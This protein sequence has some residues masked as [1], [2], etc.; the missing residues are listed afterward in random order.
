MGAEPWE[1]AFGRRCVQQGLV[2]QEAVRQ[3]Y[4]QRAPGRTLP[5]ELVARRLL[6]PAQAAEVAAWLR[7]QQPAALRASS[8]AH[9]ALPAPPPPG[10]D[11]PTVRLGPGAAADGVDDPTVRFGPGAAAEGA[12][13]LYH[14]PPS[15]DPAPDDG[16]TLRPG[17]ADDAPTVG[18]LSTAAGASGRARQPGGL[19]QPGERVGPYELTALLGKGGMGAVFRARDPRAG[20]DVALK[21]LLPGADPD[22]STLARFRREAEAV[23]R[24]DAHAGVVRVRDLGAHDGMPY[25][26]MDLVEGRDLHAIVKAEGP[27]G[28]DRALRYTE[29]VARAVHHCHVKGVLHRDLKPANVLLRA[30]DDVPLVTDFGLA[31]DRDAERLTRTGQVMGTPAYM[32]PE[33][34]DGDR[35]AVDARADVYALGAI[36]YELAAGRP[37]F[38]GGQVEVLKQVFMDMPA[39]LAPSRAD[40]PADLDV[41]VRK[42]MAKDKALRYATAADLAD[43]VARLRRGEPITARAPT[44]REELVWRR[45]RGDVR[46]R[47]V[48]AS[49]W[50]VA[51]GLAVGGAVALVAALTNTPERLLAE[52]LARLP[53]AVAR[54]DPLAP[55]EAV[56]DL[57]RQLVGL[58][59]AADAGEEAQVE[60]ARLTALAALRPG[61][62][63]LGRALHADEAGRQALEA[64]LRR[65]RVA[66]EG[67]DPAWLPRLDAPTDAASAEDHLMA[68]LGQAR[69]G[70]RDLGAADAPEAPSL[71]QVRAL[72]GRAEEAGGPVAKAAKA[73]RERLDRAAER[74]EEALAAG[75]AELEAALTD[76]RRGPRAP[77]HGLIDPAL[78]ALSEVDA[79]AR[80]FALGVLRRRKPAALADAVER[81]K[82]LFPPKDDP[83]LRRHQ[84]YGALAEA[85]RGA[86]TPLARAEPRARLREGRLVALTRELATLAGRRS[87]EAE[88]E[89][90]SVGFGDVLQ[91]G[92]ELLGD[93]G[94]DQFRRETVDAVVHAMRPALAEEKSPPM[95][96]V[97]A[98][99]GLHRLP[100]D[101]LAFIDRFRRALDERVLETFTREHR[102]GDAHLMWAE[103]LRATREPRGGDDADGRARAHWPELSAVELARIRDRFAQALGPSLTP[104][105]RERLQELA[106]PEPLD[107]PLT[108]LWVPHAR[109]WVGALTVGLALRRPADERDAAVAQARAGLELVQAFRARYG[110][111]KD[112]TRAAK[113]L[114]LE[115]R[116]LEHLLSWPGV[117]AAWRETL[118]AALEASLR[119][120]VEVG[121][122]IL[123][124]AVRAEARDDFNQGSLGGA[125]ARFDTDNVLRYLESPFVG[126]TGLLERR[127]R[128]EE[129]L[130]LASESLERLRALEGPTELAFPFTLLLRRGEL[131]FAVGRLDA[132]AAA[133]DEVLAEVARR[134]GHD[135]RSR[136][137]AVRRGND[138]RLLLARV[139][140][141][142]GDAA[143]ARALLEAARAAGDLEVDR[144]A[145]VLEALGG[146]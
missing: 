11:D 15:G 78:P 128:A 130:A 123:T 125:D 31:L 49:P 67:A 33:Q 63:P 39:P 103:L 137:T 35:A 21:L 79:R 23:A 48:L 106:T 9:A 142:R 113:L 96:L 133:A 145:P 134:P 16:V 131:A 36:L 110:E 74:V 73:A 28:V 140:L 93:W 86:I 92:L 44:W 2:P 3:A 13:T 10:V 118:E 112:P 61:D 8:G 5:D 84:P 25:A 24:V 124:L 37:P 138:A 117:D 143:A 54:D 17:A 59:P 7:R 72:L 53:A 77:W 71:E 43:D 99:P 12:P 45:R 105:E 115:D 95:A 29:A 90:A 47:L 120:Q 109:A 116:C 82:D 75:L 46:A 83:R 132:A 139:H 38:Q 136:R 111:E 80:P 102:T 52:A 87:Y 55:G 104:D 76:G 94:D 40:V 62:G 91:A 42:A 119:A 81:L 27:L 89:P 51:L 30:A 100:T 32:P 26:V 126:L 108:S 97:M 60:L 57:R 6:A 107:V 88:T 4:L 98:L 129:G 66:A 50:L 41:I 65:L 122:R 135:R 58:S 68:A 114:H 22:G 146:R 69:W 127:G 14:P 1:V 34:A 18:P 64:L 19:P 144:W 85:L 20:A 101:N 141:R 56:A 121:W 70:R